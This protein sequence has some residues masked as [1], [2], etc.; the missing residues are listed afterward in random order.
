MIAIKNLLKS[1]LDDVTDIDI[2]IYKTKTEST[3]EY[4]R[5]LN[6][7]VSKETTSYTRILTFSKYLP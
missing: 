4:K 7:K 5:P 2:K 1:N 3:K 6:D